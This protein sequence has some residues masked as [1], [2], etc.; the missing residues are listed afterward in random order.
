MSIKDEAE[1]VI[2]ANGAFPVH[3]YAQNLLL[4]AKHVVCCDGAA[5]KCIS[6]GRV[7][8]AIV[9]D[10]DSLSPERLQAFAHLLHVDTDQSCNDLTKA[11]NYCL[12]QGAKRLLILGATGLREDH[13][14]A[15]ISLLQQYSSNFERV[16]LMT[17]YGRMVAINSDTTFDSYAGQPISIFSLEPLGKI[18]LEG[19]KYQLADGVAPYWWSGTLNESLGK[20]FSI[21]CKHWLIVY[22]IFAEKEQDYT[23]AYSSEGIA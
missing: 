20:V 23:M 10:C 9:G 19:L 18:K 1:V 13:T 22:Q 14:I 11:V 4:S 16:E 17:N 15:N 21:Y 6:W 12:A 2:L 7:P 3:A 5:D 8:N